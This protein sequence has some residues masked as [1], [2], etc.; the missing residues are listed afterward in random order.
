MTGPRPFVAVPAYHL[1]NDRVA[2]WHDGGYGVPAPYLDGLR[3][4]GA[5]T[6]IVAPGENADAEEILAPFDALLLV[7]GGDIDPA[8]YDAV[9]DSAHNYGVEEDRD[10]FEIALLHAAHRS[11]LPTLCICRGMQV[12]NVAFG[13]TLHQHL[14]AMP[15]LVPHGVPVDDSIA[16]HDVRSAPASRLR[17]SAGEAPVV[18]SSHHHQGVDRV[19]EGLV[20][21]GWSSDGLV[22][23]IEL[24]DTDGSAWMLGIQWH[25]E[26]TAPHDPAQQ[27]LFDTLV[28]AGQPARV[29]E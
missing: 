23:A 29:A 7:G 20:A 15:G 16:L 6:A 19:G 4:A 8:R 10:A 5:R 1:A 26:E 13:G 12:M 18:C 27:A 22:E 9:P 3:R 14:P 2:R 21:T 25:P 24:G 28:R 11:R 17:D